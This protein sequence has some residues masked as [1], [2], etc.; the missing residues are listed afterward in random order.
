MQIERER[1]L[2]NMGFSDLGLEMEYGGGL[3]VCKECL[4]VEQTG[5]EGETSANHCKPKETV[6][7]RLVISNG[8]FRLIFCSHRL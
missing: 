7:F 1:Y 3:V 5:S 4:R 8:Q 6:N 2:M